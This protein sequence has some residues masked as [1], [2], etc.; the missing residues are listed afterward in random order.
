MNCRRLKIW[1]C[2]LLCSALQGKAQPYRH[3][4]DSLNQQLT[5][6][7][8]VSSRTALWF[9]LTDNYMELDQYDSA[10]YCLNEIARVLP[11]KT[12][13][14]ENYFLLSRQ[15]EVYYYNGLQ[16]LGLQ[17]AERSLALARA[18]RDSSLLADSY[19]FIGLFYIN[20]DSLRTA[21]DYL[22]QGLAYV[23]RP[24]LANRDWNIT[25]PHHIY[26]NLGEAYEKLGLF[27]SA[28]YCSHRSMQ[29]ARETGWD[30]GVA[31][32]QYNLGSIYFKM[33]LQDS[34]RT[35]F[36][37][38]RVSAR[39]SADADVELIACSG[40]AKVLAAAGEQ[41]VA[42]EWLMQGNRLLQAQ[43]PINA[44]FQT[45]FLEEAVD[46]Y[47]QYA[48]TGL[49]TASLQNL[50]TLRQKLLHNNNQ[51]MNILL[52]AGLQNETRLLQ[53]Q[54]QE[55]K[56]RREIITTKLYLA[57]S[58]FFVLL[59][60]FALYRYK[61]KQ[62]LQL[63]RLQNRISQDLHD[64]VGSSL[65]SMQVYSTVAD[66]LLE[67]Q[68]AQAREMLRR[69]AQESATVMENMGDIV[70]AMKGGTAQNLEQRIKNFAVA[71]LGAANL[72]YQIKI[73]EG[74]DSFIQNPEARKNVLL[75][76][77]E[78][79]NNVVRHSR[80]KNVSV[81]IKHITGHLCIQVA[82]DGVGFLK[83]NVQR[84]QGLSNM[85]KRVVGMDG[86]YELNS[87]PG[88]GTIVSAFIPIAKISETS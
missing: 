12:P 66:A 38:S 15:A 47:R 40:L 56:Q 39:R 16:R 42:L 30:R 48:Q 25:R 52:D 62:R 78:A 43:P 63:S 17:E 8:D 70:W 49:L 33:K 14:V 77:K 82:D 74:T 11:L 84:G 32:A 59:V 71:V 55:E 10:Q 45:I 53:L 44:L 21:L 58:L 76:V 24:S 1:V 60:M 81:S 86:T 67:K 73:E 13:T 19:N 35:Y 20:L 34:A 50:A 68:P 46:L 28:L 41:R 2:V 57:V 4:I 75:L 83:A 29:L 3:I 18:L 79:I 80:A 61:L 6:T 27:D 36:H 72:H 9:G 69:I 51:Q 7:T 26:G 87:S 85:Q 64:D 65:S 22:H 54:V 88:N 37:Q 23:Q 5:Q 31:V